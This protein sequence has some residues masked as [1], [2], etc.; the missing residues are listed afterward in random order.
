[1]HT[2]NIKRCPNCFKESISDGNCTC[3]FTSTNLITKTNDNRF[4]ENG[5]TLSA[6]R[7]DIGRIL[8][9]PGGFGVVYAGFDRYLHRLV[10]IKEFFPIQNDLARRNFN[11]NLVESSSCCQT[12]FHN[13]QEKFLKEAQL[14]ASLEHETT[15]KIYD[16]LKENNTYYLIMERLYGCTL[17]EHIK[18]NHSNA[19]YFI[20]T[21]LGS[22]YAKQLL[23]ATLKAL[24]F[25]HNAGI[26]HLDITPHNLFL[27]DN[28]PEKLAVIDFGMARSVTSAARF[29]VEAGNQYF[30]AP[31][32]KKRGRPTFASDYYGLGICLYTA[33]GN[34]VLGKHWQQELKDSNIDPELV[35]V[36]T[37]C[38]QANPKQRPQQVADI[39]ALLVSDKLVLNKDFQGSKAPSI[40][41]N[42]S[43][44]TQVPTPKP[45][46]LLQNLYSRISLFWS[47]IQWFIFKIAHVISTILTLPIISIIFIISSIY[48]IL[49]YKITLPSVSLSSIARI[50]V[51]CLTIS[52]T[53]ILWNDWNYYIN[54]C[55]ESKICNLELFYA[56]F[57]KQPD[58]MD[59]T[60]ITTSGKSVTIQVLKNDAPNQ[61]F[62]RVSRPQH[63]TVEVHPDWSIT[64]TPTQQFIGSDKFVYYTQSIS[65]ADGTTHQQATVYVTVINKMLQ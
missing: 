24:E 52:T 54:L 41:T 36:I 50:L 39:L 48:R 44:I 34:T 19:G 16:F 42:V 14:L 29:P 5:A 45:S 23:R 37:Q 46:S 7:Y 59:D 17:A 49:T 55:Y 6:G 56:Q 43:S 18:L 30:M 13:W 53:W 12:E 25:I 63:G 27:R 64:Y 22:K 62:V 57:H 60:A 3:G 10:A 1:M 28:D 2:N 26:L 32:L 8:G 35:A 58:V 9:G 15:I 61:K 11:S 65:A 20:A 51:L 31:E 21:P 40:A 47:G 33:L 38:M 4:L